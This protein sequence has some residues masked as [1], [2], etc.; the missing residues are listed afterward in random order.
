MLEPSIDIGR[1]VEVHRRA[2][3]LSR[4]K[5]AAMAEVSPALVKAIETGKRTLTLRTA[6]RLAPILG[7]RDLSDLYG[8]AVQ[9][10]M[11]TRATHEGMYDLRRVLTTWQL[12]VEGEPVSSEYLRGAVDMAW[13]TWHHSRQQRSEVAVLLPGM[14]EQGQ[15][16]V[17]LLE[18]AERR[19][20]KS[21]LAQTYH[22]AQ[23]YMAWHGERELVWL[24]VEKGMTTA[25]ESDDPVTIAFATWYS[26]HLLRSVGRSEE[27]LERLADARALVTAAAGDNPTTEQLAM[28]ADLWNCSA[29]TRARDHDQSAWAD[30]SNGERAVAALPAGY[31]HPWTR[32]GT[33][34]SE[35]YAVMIATELG[36]AEE[37]RRRA[38]NLDP[39]SIPSVDR[40]ARHLIELARGA[41]LDGS[42]EGTVHLLS[43]AAS[44]SAETVKF[45][46]PAREMIDRLLLSA[47]STLRADV[48]SLARATSVTRD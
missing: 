14:I 28:L 12:H 25:L 47:P 18:G 34:L 26:A 38:Q 7:V 5:L 11:G 48:E 8:D 30:W 22:L 44:V 37:A 4:E 33:V 15:R 13:S 40:Q 19:R 36:D 21:M 20:A 17:R 43:R 16:A 1:R 3:G 10:P 23:A 24:T 42:K 31:V 2:K 46:P 9:L 32:V 35:V 45:T 6:Q 29:L 39:A 41:D 27:A